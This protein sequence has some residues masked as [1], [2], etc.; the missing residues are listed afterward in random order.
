MPKPEAQRTTRNKTKIRRLKRSNQIPVFDK[1]VQKS[2]IWIKDVQ[3]EIGF[4]R[5]IDAYHLLRAVL[6]GLRDQLNVHEGA[7][8]SAQL[9]LLLRGVYYECWNPP[10]ELR[11]VATKDEFFDL[12]LSHLGPAVKL[13]VELPEGIAGVL[14]VLMRHVSEGEMR[15]V[16]NCLSPSLK[17]FIFEYQILE[18]Q[19]SSLL[20]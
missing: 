9:P 17:D 4:L 6:H 11:K 15:D 5:P 8:L 18:S 14:K 10:Q 12:V 20:N 7:H 2:K 16:V 13:S 19:Q 1:T 3:G